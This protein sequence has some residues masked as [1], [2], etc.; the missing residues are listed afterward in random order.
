M[1]GILTIIYTVRLLED[2][3]IIVAGNHIEEYHCLVNCGCTMTPST[4][5]K[6]IKLSDHCLS[7]FDLGGITASVGQCFIHSRKVIVV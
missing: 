6:I 2:E 3:N 1:T 7:M 4:E 5:Y